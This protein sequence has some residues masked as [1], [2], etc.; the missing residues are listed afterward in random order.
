MAHLSDLLGH[1]H[2]LFVYNLAQLEKAAGDSGVDVKLIAD[3]NTK[4]HAALTA[5]GLDGA[6]TFPDE[7]YQSLNAAVRRGDAEKVLRNTPYVLMLLEGEPVSLNIQDVVENAHHQLPFAER[8]LESGRRH[9]RAEI[10]RRYAEHDRTDNKMVEQLVKEA[11]L[12]PKRD[13]GHVLAKAHPNREHTPKMYAVGDMFSDVFIQLNENESSVEKDEAGNEWLKMPFGSKPPYDDAV[14]V[15]AVGPSPNAGVSAERLG[16]DVAL[17]AWQGDDKVAEANRRY[18]T[19]E[20]IDHSTIIS[21]ENTPSNTY[22]VLRRGAERTILVKNE[23]YEYDWVEPPFTPDW[24]YLSLIANDS[25]QLH[26]DMLAYLNS[27]PDM[28]FAFQPG[29][30]HF[31]WG[32]EKLKDIYARATIVIMNREE[33]VD[34]TGGDHGDIRQLSEKLHELGPDIVVITDGKHG[35][36]ALYD[37]KLVSIPNYPDIAPAFDRTGAGDAFASTIVAALALGESMETAL[38][39]APINSMN[40]VQKLG[41]QAGLQTREQIAEWLEKAPADYKVTEL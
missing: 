27:H 1:D 10:I 3:I 35:S 29:T 6:D 22:Y 28:K 38:S 40:V 7:L 23:D 36:Y 34:V 20:G 41:A 4:A 15:D 14:T 31:K 11:G 26:E 13:E 30:F 37:N 24:V 32:A 5:L 12:K 39:W 33:A 2:P 8:S 16:I 21:K 19:S 25:W 17:L 18:L 9:L